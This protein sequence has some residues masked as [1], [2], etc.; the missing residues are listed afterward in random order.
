MNQ[1]TTGLPGG[2]PWRI[3]DDCFAPTHNTERA[4][5]RSSE[6]GKK[7]TCPRARFL[8][9]RFYDARN[10]RMRRPKMPGNGP[11]LIRADCP[12]RSYHNTLRAAEGRDRNGKCI[13]PRATYLHTTTRSA[14]RAAAKARKEKPP[15]V[16]KAPSYEARVR[17]PDLSAGECALPEN[18]KSVDRSYLKGESNRGIAEMRKICRRCPIQQECGQYVLAAESPAGSWGGVWGGMTSGE[19]I[20]EARRVNA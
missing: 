19:R 13:C 6:S 17:M 1:W 9:Q 16:V 3:D 11:W 20:R 2:G 10:A 4:S 5:I 8:L 18:R 15:V 12:G 7:C 14:E